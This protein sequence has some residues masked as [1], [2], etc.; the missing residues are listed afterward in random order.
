MLFGAA[1][2]SVS[3]VKVAT[4]D[5]ASKVTLPLNPGMKKVLLFV[6]SAGLHLFDGLL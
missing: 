5:P 6:V 3:G 1:G 4:L 2:L